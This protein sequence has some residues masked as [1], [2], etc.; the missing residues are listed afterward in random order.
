MEVKHKKDTRFLFTFDYELFLG[1][2]TGS[3][4]R[5]LLVPTE[6]LLDLGR[7]YGVKY[8][9]FVDTLFLIKLHEESKYIQHLDADYRNVVTQLKKASLEGHEIGLHL[10]PQWYYSSYDTKNNRWLLDYK[11]Y[12]LADCSFIDIEKMVRLS[13]ELINEITGTPPLSYRAG[14]YS[15]P[16]TKEFW[17][18][19]RDNGIRYDTSVIMGEQSNTSFQS[20]DYSYLISP[21]PFRFSYKNTVVDAEGHFMEFPISTLVV[22]RLFRAIVEKPLIKIYHNY[23]SVFGDGKGVGFLYDK[24][25]PTSQKPG[26]LDPIRLRSSVDFRNAVWAKK[27][28]KNGIRKQYPYIVFIGH[29]KNQTEYS[30]KKIEQLLKN[31]QFAAKVITFRDIV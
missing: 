30:L 14:G 19:L 22:S 21:I 8:V 16:N 12:K 1:P 20:Y 24:Q 31:R 5:C 9:F 4:E 29:P 23:L 25:I 11:H 18:L 10:H 28:I 7:K 17:D 13:C 6:R 27:F 15:A 26:L 3:I 2:E